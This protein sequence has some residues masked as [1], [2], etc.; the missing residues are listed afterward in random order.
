MVVADRWCSDATVMRSVANAHRGPLLVQGKRSSPFTLEDGRKGKGADVV[1]PATWSWQPRLHTPGCRSVR[2]RAWSPP[3]GQV[4]LVVVDKPGE[5]PFSL[6][7]LSL[8]MPVTRL[9]QAWHQRHGIEPMVR[10]LQHL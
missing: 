7:S 4:L 1:N 2:L 6:L 8:T 3:S 5:K 10:L 9:M